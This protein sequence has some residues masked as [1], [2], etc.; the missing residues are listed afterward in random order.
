MTG[1][2]LAF[3]IQLG[4]RSFTH[5]WLG[6]WFGLPVLL[7]VV[8]KHLSVNLYVIVVCQVSYVP[9]N[10]KSDVYIKGPYEACEAK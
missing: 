1:L 2:E 9:M 10:L 8:G 4:H 5:L 3:S 7:V 6:K